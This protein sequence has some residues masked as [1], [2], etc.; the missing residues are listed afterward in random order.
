[1]P[2]TQPGALIDWNTTPSERASAGVTID[3]ARQRFIEARNNLL[4]AAIAFADGESS[5]QQLIAMRKIYQVELEALERLSAGAS[6][7]VSDASVERIPPPPAPSPRP[8]AA[9]VAPTKPVVGEDDVRWA[10]D[11]LDTK[12]EAIEAEFRSGRI[13]EAQ[14]RAIVKHYQ[15]QREVVRRLLAINPSSDRWRVVLAEGKTRFLRT[16][17]EAQFV[18]FALYDVRTQARLYSVGTLTPDVEAELPL[19]RSFHLPSEK[20]RANEIFA[21]DLEDG[22]SLACVIGDHTAALVVF[23]RRPPAWQLNVYYEVHANFE[24]ANRGQLARGVRD[25]RRLVFPDLS[26]LSK[27]SR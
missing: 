17:N 27:G 8:S 4:A 14:H 9:P 10:V 2:S 22:R 12:L 7:V 16:V 25:P 20:R 6:A 23:S 24:A 18:G 26:R 1:M 15:E 21:T 3:T 11:Q 13:N 19:L 5:G